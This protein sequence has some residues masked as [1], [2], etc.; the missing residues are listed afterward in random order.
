MK[1]IFPIVFH[2]YLFCQDQQPTLTEGPDEQHD[3]G[4][5]RSNFNYGKQK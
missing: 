3:P 4:V 5:L 2:L 1:A